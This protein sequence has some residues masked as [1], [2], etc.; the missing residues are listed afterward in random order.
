ME[1]RPAVIVASFVVALSTACAPEGAPRGP[2]TPQ[3]LA[4]R[5]SDEFAQNE[6]GL[7]TAERL[8]Q[9]LA[10]WSTHK[11]ASVKGE[12]IVLQFDAAAG[13]APWVSKREG[14]RT[15]QAAELTRLMEP[16][17]NG[18][19]AIGTV[20]SN[21]IRIDSFM[22]RFSMR[23][24]ED[25][26]LFVT[27][28]ATPES[29]AVLARAWLAFRYWGW[30]HSQ[31]GV[32]NGS[33]SALPVTSRSA[34][35]DAHPFGGTVRINT[36]PNEH[37]ALLADLAAVRDAIG[38]EPIVDV[39]APA[40]F[41]GSAHGTS[42]FDSTCLGGALSCTATFSGR[43]A[44]A[45]N[46]PARGLQNPDGTFKALGELDAATSSLDRQRA[47]YLYDLDGYDSAIAAFALL[48]VVGQPV[49]WYAA[50]FIEW[51][52]FNASH[53]VSALRALPA[54]SPWR[55]DDFP[56]LTEGANAWSTT[57][58]GVRPLVFDAAAPSSD[59]VQRSDVE[60]RQNPPA[61]PAVGAGEGGC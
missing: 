7:I 27:G 11:P 47:A 16:R 54:N 28:E 35:V 21:G 2:A 48:G 51:G 6:A 53:P 61:L 39:R 14:V 42:R 57:E 38:K 58:H 29:F 50:S 9:W 20:P 8:E 12:L 46:V 40:E 36:I 45:V 15:Y 24:N 25:F 19:A 34:T 30:E 60:Y 1:I 41:D 23:P 22:R 3:Q 17:N 13:D 56:A 33:I 26:V 4:V 52:A 43:I 55:T 31:L 44:G 5:S 18:I 59:G 32:L 10:S 49:R 37:F